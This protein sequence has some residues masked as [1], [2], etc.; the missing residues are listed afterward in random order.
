MS[1]FYAFLSSKMH[2]EQRKIPSSAMGGKRQFVRMPLFAMEA[3]NSKA[4]ACNFELR[5]A[6]G[7]F[8]WPGLPALKLVFLK[9]ICSLTN[10][11]RRWEWYNVFRQFHLSNLAHCHTFSFV[12]CI[13]GCHSRNRSLRK[14]LNQLQS[15][16]NHTGEKGIK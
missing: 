7:W 8:L 14:C 10:Y 2:Q 9:R 5:L 3:L 1:I 4:I 12:E 13:L 11:L 15:P 6:V 16:A